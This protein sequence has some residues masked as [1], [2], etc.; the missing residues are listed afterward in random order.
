MRLAGFQQIFIYRDGQQDPGSWPD[1][2]GLLP[3]ALFW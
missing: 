3:P 1:S 2:L